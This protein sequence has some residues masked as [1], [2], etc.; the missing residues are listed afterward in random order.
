[1][2]GSV[3][4]MD[5]ASLFVGRNKSNQL[6]LSYAPPLGFRVREHYFAARD[7]LLG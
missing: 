3:K 4:G 6:D 1:M 2:W 5:E 7:V